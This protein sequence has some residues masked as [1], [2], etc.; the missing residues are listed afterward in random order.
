MFSKIKGL[1]GK[2]LNPAGK[3]VLA[4]SVL[5]ALPTYPMTCVKI[6]RVSQ[7]FWSGANN[8][9]KIHCIGWGKLTDVKGKG[10]GLGFRDLEA[11]NL[12]SL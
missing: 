11:F 4:K 8:T 3:E 7:F 1:K 5:L 10:T 12:G 2:L 6:P 9:R